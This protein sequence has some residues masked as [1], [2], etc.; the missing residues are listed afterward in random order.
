M[1]QRSLSGCE[2]SRL[3]WEPI[4]AGGKEGESLKWYRNV[5]FS[6]SRSQ[7]N[8]A[9]YEKKGIEI[10]V[11]LQCHQDLSSSWIIELG[12]IA[13]TCCFTTMFHILKKKATSVMNEH[14]KLTKCE[15][16]QYFPRYNSKWHAYTFHSYTET[17]LIAFIQTD[18]TK[19]Q[20][21]HSWFVIS[22]LIFLC[23]CWSSQNKSLTHGVRCENI[24]TLYAVLIHCCCLTLPSL[25]RPCLLCPVAS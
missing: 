25:F 24:L 7:R 21:T 9:G 6:L 17:S 20:S 11:L 19:K 10:A 8:R 23:H 15:E 4:A 18:V 5:R 16:I 22:S 14:N 12:S 3:S 1:W 13:G 2:K